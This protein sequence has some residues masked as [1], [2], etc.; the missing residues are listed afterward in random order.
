VA[1][2]SAERERH[3]FELDLARLQARMVEHVV[4]QCQQMIGRALQRLQ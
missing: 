2:L 1:Q 3:A 4:D